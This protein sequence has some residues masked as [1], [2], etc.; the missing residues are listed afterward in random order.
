VR[1]QI[2]QIIVS[3]ELKHN[4]PSNEKRTR[5]S[6]ETPK[7]KSWFPHSHWNQKE[8][9]NPVSVKRN[10]YHIPFF[11]AKVMGRA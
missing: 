3:I 2:I 7:E 8:S 5:I 10:K 11:S 6:L 1:P 4:H 9:K